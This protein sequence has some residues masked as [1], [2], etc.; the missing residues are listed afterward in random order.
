MEVT[1]VKGLHK[2]ELQAQAKDLH[3]HELLTVFT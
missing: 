1:Q 3:R 2:H